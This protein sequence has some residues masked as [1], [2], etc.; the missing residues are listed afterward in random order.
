MGDD[1][2]VALLM[3]AQLINNAEPVKAQT[4]TRIVGII[5]YK[6]VAIVKSKQQRTRH[7]DEKHEDN[8][9]L[10]IYF[11]VEIKLYCTR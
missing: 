6:H 2:R 4:P 3:G 5:R 7:D 10:Y 11:F 1:A 9:V 8:K